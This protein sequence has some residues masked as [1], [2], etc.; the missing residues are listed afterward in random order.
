MRFPTLKSLT[1]IMALRSLL[2]FKA[3]SFLLS[4]CKQ[5]KRKRKK[6]SRRRQLKQK[7]AKTK[8]NQQQISKN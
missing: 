3:S 8:K 1:C 7:L 6:I 4:N 5:L 2:F